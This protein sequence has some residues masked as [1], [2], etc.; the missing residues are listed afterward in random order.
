MNSEIFR[1]LNDAITAHLPHLRAE[2]VRT[3]DGIV[4]ARVDAADR[5]NATPVVITYS[6]D[7]TSSLPD[8]RGR[9]ATDWRYRGTAPDEV[10]V[11]RSGHTQRTRDGSSTRSATAVIITPE[12]RSTGSGAYRSSTGNGSLP[13]PICRQS[14][15]FCARAGTEN[16]HC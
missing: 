1:Q 2:L 4:V 16:A 13:S 11:D 8:Q 3:E 10:F 15:D 9:A 14:S 7:A 5:E 6:D 12:R